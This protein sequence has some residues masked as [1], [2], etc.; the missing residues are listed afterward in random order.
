MSSGTA[1]SGL[2]A[3]RVTRRKVTTYV[4]FLV[5]SVLLMAVS[6][7]PVVRELQNGVAFA[8]RPIEEGVGSVA[9]N[10]VSIGGAL[11]DIEQL[12]RDNEALRAE[13]ER[14]R[15]E[16]QAA[17]E[18]RRENDLLTGLLQL[19]QGLDFQTQA[20]TV[21]A[22]ESSDSLR[23]IIIDRGSNDGIRIGHVV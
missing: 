3:N 7:N 21:I 18:A 13:N 2:L 12:R 22:R 17:V 20:A 6:G 23:I 14:L 9:G 1:P 10:V 4:A 16:N 19:Q 8:F 5:A 15:L 11:S